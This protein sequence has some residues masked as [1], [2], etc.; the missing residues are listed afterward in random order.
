MKKLI[1]KLI[2]DSQNAFGEAGLFSAQEILY[3]SPCTKPAHV[4]GLIK[5]RELKNKGRA[6]ALSTLL[7]QVRTN[8]NEG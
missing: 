8:K 3:Q 1:G 6:L 2:G 5:R 4:V 7:Y